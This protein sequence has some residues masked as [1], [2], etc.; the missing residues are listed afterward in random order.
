MCP[1]GAA[2]LG[3]H[4]GHEVG[5]AHVAQVERGRRVGRG[6]GA[7]QRRARALTS[8][9]T[10]DLPA[11]NL[12]APNGVIPDDLEEAILELKRE[13]NAVLL[14]HYYQESETQ[15]LADFV[16]D[17]LELSRTAGKVDRDVIVFCGV[18][19]MA[20]TAKILNPE[21]AVVIPDTAAGCSL[22]DGCP[23]V[24]F[25]EFIFLYFYNTSN[26]NFVRKRTYRITQ[27]NRA[28]WIGNR[29]LKSSA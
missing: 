8:G 11:S 5:A 26:I 29:N 28:H 21:R 2:P 10:A 24:E 16:G 9:M 19:F 23:A 1:A 27:I 13:R 25:R 3:L 14:A 6:A 4:R 22:A 20:E 12:P 7:S 17:S 15:D 18:H